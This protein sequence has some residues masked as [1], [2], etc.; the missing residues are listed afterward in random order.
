MLKHATEWK[1]YTEPGDLVGTVSKIK[2]KINKHYYC[3]KI[4]YFFKYE[5]IQTISFGSLFSS[6]ASI[7]FSQYSIGVNID[8]TEIILPLGV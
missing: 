4:F 2:I 7:D 1:F 8:V 6:M 5:F 3:I